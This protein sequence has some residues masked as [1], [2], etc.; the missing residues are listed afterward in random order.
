LGFFRREK[1]HERLLREGGLSDGASERAPDPIDVGPPEPGL[2]GYHGVQRPRHWDA[3]VMAQAPDL[4]GDETTFVV[5]AD[6]SVVLDEE[7]PEPAVEPIAEALDQMLDAPYRVEA[8]RRQDDIW[9]AAA[10]R[11][12]LLELSEANGEELTLTMQDGNR[13]LTVDGL[14]EFGSAPELE[15]FAAERF[16]SYVAVANRLDGH[17]YEV[18]VSPL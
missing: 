9:A 12:D 16:D 1:L 7:L 2:P 13:S 5:L 18:R 11:V 15:R 14:P 8:V 17:L 3:V 10:R 4:P 6:G